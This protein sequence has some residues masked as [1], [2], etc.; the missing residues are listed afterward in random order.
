MQNRRRRF[1][2][3]V[4]RLAPGVTL[5][6]AQEEV[7]LINRRLARDYPKSDAGSGCLSVLFMQ[8]MVKDVRGT[9][10][11]LLSAVGLVL[12]IAC[13][14]IASLFLIRAVSRER[15]LA[16]RVALGAGRGRLIRQCMT[17]SA[18]LG[19]CGGLLGIFAAAVSLHPFV[20]LWPGSLPRADEIRIDWR[21]LCFA[22]GMSLVCG[23][24]F[25]L[26]PALRVPMRRL[27]QALRGGGRTV[28]AGSR[29]LHSPFVIS[30]IALAVV[31]LVS[32]GMLGHTLL[33]L[34]SLNPGL[35]PRNVLTAR[36]AI[37]PKCDQQ[38]ITDSLGVAGCAGSR[39]ASTGCAIRRPG[40][41]RPDA[42][43]RKRS[44]PTGPRPPP[45]SRSGAVRAGFQRHPRLPQ[46]HGHPA[47]SGPLLR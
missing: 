26:A 9:L 38:P 42:R 24:L 21:V 19:L 18:V 36:F 16:M 11:L 7:T 46:G 30:E 6:Q 22:I 17:E 5:N 41:H 40:R 25:G 14:N 27:E 44:D 1:V 32:A 12:F 29:H 34:S 10:W 15:E 8:D 47:A 45:D 31:L 4:A 2:N 28:T 35:D 37:S 20:A 39:A 13:V 33:T 23:L 3:V 43:G